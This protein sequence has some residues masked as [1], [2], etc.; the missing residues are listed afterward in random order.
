[1]M[2]SRIEQILTKIADHETRLEKLETMSRPS[3]SVLTLVGASTKQKTLRELIKGK[4]FNNGQEQ[5]SAIVGYHEVLL[6]QKINKERIK[7]EWVGAK[8]ENK[9]DNKFINRAKDDLIRIHADGTCDL[10]QTGEE[11]FTT[12]LKNESSS[13]TS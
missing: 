8:M 6:G 11:F 7:H 12:L 5:V 3:E 13:A 10:T 4:N 9:F 1:M 2:D